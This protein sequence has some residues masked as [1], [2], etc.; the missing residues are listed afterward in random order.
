MN[1]KAI[2]TDWNILQGFYKNVMQEMQSQGINSLTTGGIACVIYDLAESTKDCDIIIPEDRA[3]DIV[4]TLAKTELDG[5]RFHLTLKYGAPLNSRWLQGG[6]SSHTFNGPIKGTEEK[7]LAR[8]DFFGRAPRVPITIPDEKYPLYLSRDGVARMKKTRRDKD[9]AYTNLLGHQMLKRGETSGILHVTDIKTIIET[10]KKEQI[11]DAL[12]YERPILQLA[13]DGNPELER[14]IIAE[15]GFW[16]RLDDLRL[17]TYEKAW[18]PY[19][20]AIQEQGKALLAMD[21]KTQN[22]AMSEI[23]Q[24]ELEQT[25]INTVVWDNLIND[26]K[27]QTARIFQNINVDLLPTPVAFSRENGLGR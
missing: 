7:P 14:Y 13:L 20:R 11:S 3:S 21:L 26:A 18:A 9:W 4:D 22:E 2:T 27:E 6:W 16:V 5:H 25:P 8:L 24:Q 23:A 12:I 17:S 1:T 19:G 15:K 10:C